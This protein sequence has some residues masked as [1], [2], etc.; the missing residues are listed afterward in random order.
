MEQK[1]GTP[2]AAVKSSHSKINLSSNKMLISQTSQVII[3]TFIWQ[4]SMLTFE[5]GSRELS[6]T[7]TRVYNVK[8]LNHARKRKGQQH[9]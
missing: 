5:L 9:T 4:S 7:H 6:C 8:L 2:S 3:T 1:E